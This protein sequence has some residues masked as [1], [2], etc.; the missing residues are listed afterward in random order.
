MKVKDL[1]RATDR[2]DRIGAACFPIR[3]RLLLRLDRKS[4]IFH[5]GIAGA[6]AEE[7][8]LRA[9]ARLFTVARG[10]EGLDLR[11]VLRSLLASGIES[12]M[13]EG[14]AQGPG[15]PEFVS[16][17]R[18]PYDRDLVIWGSLAHG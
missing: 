5:A 15:I 14:G 8:L 6:A 17:V 4:W 16:C 11:E 13:V 2:S 9:G 7:E 18:E 10:A 1:G 12:V 3:A